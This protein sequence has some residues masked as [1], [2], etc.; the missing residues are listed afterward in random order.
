M[1]NQL[2]INRYLAWTPADSYRTDARWKQCWIGWKSR[3]FCQECKCLLVFGGRCCYESGP[4]PF[5]IIVFIRKFT[6]NQK[7]GLIN[8]FLILFH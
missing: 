1:V 6:I 4:F 8:L 2:S 5:D 7:T 3:L